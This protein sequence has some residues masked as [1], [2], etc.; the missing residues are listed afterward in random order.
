M[1]KPE[2]LCPICKER[3]IYQK[4]ILKEDHQYSMFHDG[5]KLLIDDIC[6]DV[7]LN[8]TYVSLNFKKWFILQ[9]FAFPN[10]MDDI[11]KMI[12]ILKKIIKLENFE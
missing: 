1:K 4:C 6:I 5:F 8:H 12:K 10:N 9:T 11:N 3:T 7:H 2:I